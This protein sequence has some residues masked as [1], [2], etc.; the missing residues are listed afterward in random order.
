VPG[1]PAEHRHARFTQLAVTGRLPA[2]GR[3]F[4]AEI[5]LAGNT[6]EAE[7]VSGTTDRRFYP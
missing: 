1:L 4:E 6:A 5:Q 3:L 7:L 2:R